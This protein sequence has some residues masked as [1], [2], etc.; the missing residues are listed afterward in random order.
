MRDHCLYRTSSN[1]PLVVVLV[2]MFIAVLMENFE[3]A[4]EEKRQ[5]QIQQFIRKTET[6]VE[7]DPVISKWNIYRY[8]RPHPKGLNVNNIPA[9]LVWNA[10]K[11]VVRDFM[12]DEGL[13][14]AETLVREFSG[15]VRK[16]RIDYNGIRMTT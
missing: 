12:A 3:T 10:K 14:L 7:H 6:V 2:N 4:E 9:N 15:S 11:N 16:R 13:Y 1:Q 8:F 5:R